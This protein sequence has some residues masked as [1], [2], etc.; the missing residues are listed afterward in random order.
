M[1]FARVEEVLSFSAET[2]P[3][4]GTPRAACW[5]LA[6][7]TSAADNVII[8]LSVVLVI[9]ELQDVVAHGASACSPDRAL[10]FYTVRVRCGTHAFLPRLDR[11]GTPTSLIGG[12]SE[13][14]PG[15]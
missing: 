13:A 2:N 14:P 6:S 11:P 15:A 8:V 9:F 7:A 5:N 4:P 3:A 12:N 10:V 1:F